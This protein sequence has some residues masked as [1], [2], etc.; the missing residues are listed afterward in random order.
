M[1]SN[2]EKMLNDPVVK[3]IVAENPEATLNDVWRVVD[4]DSPWGKKLG[5]WKDTDR[6]VDWMEFLRELIG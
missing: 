1:I 3:Q 2:A 6:V 4:V 5:M